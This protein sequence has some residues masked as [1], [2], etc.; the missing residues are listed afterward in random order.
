MNDAIRCTNCGAQLAPA[1]LQAPT[2]KYCGATHPHVARAAE[3]VAQVQ[4]LLAPG[5]GGIPNA[6]Q[7]MIQPGMM[8]PQYG[9]PHGGPLPPRG[10]A[11]P[12]AYGGPMGSAG[13]VPAMYGAPDVGR[14]MR[15][16]IGAIVLVVVAVSFLVMVA[17]GVGAWLLM[18]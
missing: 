12:P 18:R 9:A 4:A 14:A 15:R 7:G 1:D 5:P 11:S 6:L 16:G 17:G 8:P 13:Q 2:C 10:A 3:K